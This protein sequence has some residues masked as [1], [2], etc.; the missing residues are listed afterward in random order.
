M[1]SAGK[2]TFRKIA[3]GGS[4]APP[5]RHSRYAVFIRKRKNMKKKSRIPLAAIEIKLQLLYYT[6]LKVKTGAFE[7]K[8]KYGNATD[9]DDSFG[10]LC[11]DRDFYLSD[12]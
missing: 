5:D 12:Y 11:C 2:I 10:K 8:N 6:I 9:G 1:C 3:A 7:R 4:A